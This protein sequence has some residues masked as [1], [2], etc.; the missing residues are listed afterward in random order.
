ME[1]MNQKK[2]Y[3]FFIGKILNEI[4]IELKNI[5]NKIK[6]NYIIGEI[7]ISEKNV[8]KEIRIINS[9]EKFMRQYFYSD[10]KEEYKNEKEIKKCKIEINNI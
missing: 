10:I 9:Y 1:V 7:Y 5:N 8:G 4:E 6:N 2:N 3:G